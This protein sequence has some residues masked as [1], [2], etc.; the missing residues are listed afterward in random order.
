VLWLDHGNLM[1]F[2]DTDEVVTAYLD[3]MRVGNESAV[4]EDL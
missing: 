4:L 3:F 2:G 1:G